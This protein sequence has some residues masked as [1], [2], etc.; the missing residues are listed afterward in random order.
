MI[1]L[2]FFEF[3][4]VAITETEYGLPQTLALVSREYP[5][6]VVPASAWQPVGKPED[7]VAGEA[8]IRKYYLV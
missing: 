6:Q 2:Q 3:P 1:T 5:V 4:L 7:L 8:F